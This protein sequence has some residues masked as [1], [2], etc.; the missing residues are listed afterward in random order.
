MQA[1]Y[2][3]FEKATPCSE[4]KPMLRFD[5]HNRFDHFGPAE[6]RRIQISRARKDFCQRRGSLCAHKGHGI[7]FDLRKIRRRRSF[8]IDAPSAFLAKQVLEENS[9]GRT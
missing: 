3:D 4:P 8:F 7:L 9:N 2:D 6:T 5:L 1:M